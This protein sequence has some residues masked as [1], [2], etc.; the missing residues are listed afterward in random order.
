MA[1]YSSTLAWKIPWMEKHGR[2]QSMGSQRGTCAVAGTDLAEAQATGATLRPRSGDATESARLQRHKSGQ[3]ELPKVRGLGQRPR[4]DTTRP[5][6]GEVAREATP[7]PRSSSCAGKG[8]PRGAT[9]RSRSGGPAVR[10][11]PSSEVRSSG[12]TLLEQL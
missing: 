7:H 4:R 1:T 9:P 10:R 5:R 11:Y 6:S 2:L 3:E 8:G 12:C